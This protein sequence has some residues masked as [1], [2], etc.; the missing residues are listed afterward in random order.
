MPLLSRIMSVAQHL[1]VFSTERS[2]EAAV[3]VLQKRSRHWFDPEIVKVVLALEANG[4][5]WQ[6][7]LASRRKNGIATAEQEAQ[8]Q[9]D[10]AVPCSRLILSPIAS[11]QLRKSIT[12]VLL[13]PTSSTRNRPS[14]SVI[15]TGSRQSADNM[16]RVMG[17]SEER[18]HLVHRAA[19]LHDIGKLRV[20]NTILD[21]PGPLTSMER[22]LMEEHPLLTTQILSRV[23]AFQELAKV[24]GAHHERLDGSGYPEHLTGAELSLEMRLLA[25][26]DV[27]SALTEDRPYRK[28][29]PIDQV[30]AIMQEQGAP[31]AGCALF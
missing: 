8:E 27:Y 15:R 25:V 17:L 26:A 12:S 2:P 14:P 20:P 4:A 1:D 31:Q 28:P 29:M 13:L 3:R 18:R 9:A 7:C 19:L 21:K 10:D 22:R 16:A 11:S 24:A 6:G 5:L 30:I 23:A